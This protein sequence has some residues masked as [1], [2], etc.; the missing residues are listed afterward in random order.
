MVFFAWGLSDTGG[1]GSRKC[2]ILNLLLGMSLFFS[3][4]SGMKASQRAIVEKVYF[5]GTF[6]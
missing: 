3:F 4:A 2:D 1:G 6:Y 5:G